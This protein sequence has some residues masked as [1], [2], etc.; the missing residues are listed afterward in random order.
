MKLN[1]NLTVQHTQLSV[2]ATPGDVEVAS[3]EKGASAN[4]T[5]GVPEPHQ[6]YQ[7]HEQE[8]R[9]QAM[10]IDYAVNPDAPSGY[11]QPVM[12]TAAPYAYY[13]PMTGQPMGHEE[14]PV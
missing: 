11:G 1:K 14:M 3:P 9:I 5:A 4:M 13:A 8:L 12:Q 2:N 6:V 7:A 10:G